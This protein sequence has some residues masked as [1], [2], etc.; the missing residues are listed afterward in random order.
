MKNILLKPDTIFNALCMSLK[1]IVLLTLLLIAIL[2]SK[3][4]LDQYTSKSTSFKEYEEYVTKTE[5]LTIVLGFWPLKGSHN[6]TTDTPFQSFEQ[7]EFGKDFTL[8]FGVTNFKT[9]EETIHL[10]KNKQD[11]VITHSSIGKVEVTKLVA[12]FGNHYKIS[13]NIIHVKPPF[14]AFLQVTF[15]ENIL[16]KDIPMVNLR[17]SSEENS[18]G[19]TMDHWFDGK[20]IS[21]Q[22]VVGFRWVEFQPRKLVKMKSLGKCADY[23]FYRCFESQLTKQEFEKCP[24][25]CFSISTYNKNTTMLCKTKEEFRCSQEIAHELKE[26]SDCLSACNIIDI[27]LSVQYQEDEDHVDARRNVTFGYR[28]ANPKMKVKEEFLIQDFVGMLGSIGG[29]LGLFVGFSFT[30]VLSFLFD[31][32]HS[33]A[34]RYLTQKS[35]KPEKHLSLNIVKVKPKIYHQEDQMKPVVQGILTKIE[36]IEMEIK[37]LNLNNSKY[38]ALLQEMGEELKKLSKVLGIVKKRKQEKNH[39]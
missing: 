4:V 10:Q 17:I 32:L 2:I 26:T 13:A 24:R 37:D 30:G 14:W 25:K 27:D 34:K 35:K 28:I 20:V 21:F 9:A 8:A 3:D 19:I 39:E 33:F 11:M 38:D 16:A 29:T 22:D 1:Y 6:A 18:Y 12:R 23:G 5:S 31:N 36:S 15:N 7:L